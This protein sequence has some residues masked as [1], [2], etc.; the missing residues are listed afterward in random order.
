MRKQ[1]GLRNRFRS[2]RSTYSVKG[3]SKVG[4]KYG[5]WDKGTQTRSEVVNGK[6]LT[7]DARKQTWNGNGR[8]PSWFFSKL[9]IELN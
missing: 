2:G 4:D 1:T 5:A 8:V 9:H 7:Y 6:T 3:K